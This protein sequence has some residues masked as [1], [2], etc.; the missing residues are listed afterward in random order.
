MTETI[1]QE[2]DKIKGSSKFLI[3]LL[4]LFT[5]TGLIIF[6]SW[7]GLYGNKTTAEIENTGQANGLFISGITITLIGTAGITAFWWWHHSYHS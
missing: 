6:I 4:I 5:L 3:Y 1:V 2:I 7:L